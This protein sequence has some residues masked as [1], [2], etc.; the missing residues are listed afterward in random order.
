MKYKITAK[1]LG[2]EEKVFD[3]TSKTDL[4]LRMKT[5][6]ILDKPTV[7]SIDSVVEEKEDDT[8]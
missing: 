1:L 4:A 8:T 6:L 2:G 7:S 3:V 5:N